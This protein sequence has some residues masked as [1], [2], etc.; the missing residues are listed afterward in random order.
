MSEEFYYIRNKGFVGNCWIF[1]AE[2]GH[3]YTCDLNKAW[4]LPKSEAEKICERP[5]DSL[6]LASVADSFAQRH[7]TGFED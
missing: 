5:E 4:K 2:G 3:G 6:V 7:V 1:W